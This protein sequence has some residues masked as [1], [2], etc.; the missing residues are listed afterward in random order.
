MATAGQIRQGLIQRGY[1]PHIADAFI[2][3]MED[4]SGLDPGINEA[5]PIVPGSRGG[6]GLYQLTGPRRRQYEAFAAERGVPPADV[7][8]QLDFLDLELRT[9]ERRAADRI[10]AADNTADAAVAIVND[11]L[12]PSEEHRARRAARYAGGASVDTLA[13]GEGEDD[14]G[15]PARFSPADLLSDP[16]P[17]EET[18]ASQVYF[19][20]TSLLADP[21]T[22]AEAYSAPLVPFPTGEP[23][24]IPQQPFFDITADLTEDPRALLQATGDS[25]MGRG[26]SVS[27]QFLPDWLPAREGFG[28]TLD[29]PLGVAGVA[30]LGFSGL[31]GGAADVAEGLGVPRAD[32]LARDV[33][34]IP[35]AL[36]GTPTVLA[37]GAGRVA[38]E[39]AEEVAEVAPD[40]TVSQLIREAASNNPA[41]RREI[42]ARA[43]FNTEAAEAAQRLEIDLPTDVFA[44]DE[45]IQTAMGMV[46]GVRDSDAATEW[47][48]Q[49]RSAQE[50]ASALMGDAGSISDLSAQAESVKR[51]LRQSIDDLQAEAQPI[52]DQ[53]KASV[54]KASQVSMSSSK[55]YLDQVVADFGGTS[56][57][58]GPLKDLHENLTN[59][60]GMT[61]A[62]LDLEIRELAKGVFKNQGPYAGIDDRIGQD[63]WRVMKDDQRNF[64]E[65]TVGADN[66]R[67]IDDANALWSQA[68]DIEKRLVDGFGRDAEGSIANKLRS[69]LTT[70]GK[71]DVKGLSSV[72]RVI[73]DN[74]RKE[75]IMTGLDSLSQ[76]RSGQGGFSFAQ[77]AKT[78][79]GLRDNKEAFKPIAKALGSES[80]NLLND[81]YGIAVRIDRA[82]GKIDRTGRAN[83]ALLAEGLVT[84]MLNSPGG[85][86]V[87]GGL[88]GGAIS[89]VAGPLIG[90][91]LAVTAANTKIGRNKAAVFSRTMRSHE[92]RSMAEEAARTGQISEKTRLR[93]SRS[94]AF[95]QWARV[96]NIDNPDAWLISAIAASQTTQASEV[97]NVGQ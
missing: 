59:K 28:R 17:V 73:P 10:F 2:L 69:A 90:S 50:R 92:F 14:L 58:R 47:G 49:F 70:A 89:T 36:A 87:K 18:P 24:P 4:E 95:R 65:A 97:E 6:F 91:A 29:I 88:A 9:T 42:A 3:N 80:V 83:Q 71:G 41:A 37:R 26:P 16:A 13:G 11:F 30:D 62:A 64:V 76:A 33:M 77:F 27:A 68:R 56:R 72:L 40:L 53:V 96:N 85:Q 34:A 82:S 57:L 67:K 44:D 45:L 94:Q 74:L 75:A 31:V 61:Y 23:E 52:Y 1:A 20:P 5:A 93:V 35:E 81:L 84:S 7:D 48:E 15:A 60:E 79:R 25:I 8:A 78:Y 46:R 66:A 54:P 12:R 86:V 39:A 21:P 55:A 32:V 63:V 38:R 51:S 43:R 19:S 22:V